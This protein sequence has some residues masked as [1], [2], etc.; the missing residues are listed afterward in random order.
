MKPSKETIAFS[1]KEFENSEDLVNSVAA[2]K[3]GIG[4]VGWA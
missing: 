4:Y 3:S 2:D 1:A